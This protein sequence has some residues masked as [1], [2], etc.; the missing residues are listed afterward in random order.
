LGLKSREQRK[1]TAQAKV[2]LAEEERAITANLA[3]FPE[4]TG[5]SVAVAAYGQELLQEE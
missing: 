3:A 2:L 1:V 5:L 4:R